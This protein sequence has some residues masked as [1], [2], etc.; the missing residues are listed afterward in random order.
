M[1]MEYQPKKIL[2]SN[3]KAP[4]IFQQK[5]WSILA[6]PQNRIPK[7]LSQKKMDP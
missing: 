6:D 4:V 2:G 7:S 1:L 3:L 5:I